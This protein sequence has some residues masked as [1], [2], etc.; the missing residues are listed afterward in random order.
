MKNEA[1]VALFFLYKKRNNNQTCFPF[2]RGHI[3]YIHGIF[4]TA[5][6]PNLRVRVMGV[7]A[8][9]IIVQGGGP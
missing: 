9:Y 4:G 5:V 1:A 2:L 3:Q 8:V 7:G 6:G